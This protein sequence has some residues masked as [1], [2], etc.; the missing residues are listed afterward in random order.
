MRIRAVTR[1]ELPLLAELERAAGAPFAEIGMPE[2]AEDEPP[3]PGELAHY[4]ERG[5]ALVAEAP[6][7][8]IAGY[9]LAEPVDGALHVEQVSVHPDHARRGI[10]RAL[11]EHLAGTTDAPAL[12]LTTFA[13]V[14]WNAP[15]YERCGFRALAGDELTP[16]L[17]EIR[18]REAEHGLDRWPRLCM[19]RD[20]RP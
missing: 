11:I 9:L 20:L 10:G 19:R 1:D 4:L 15:Y 5:V 17:R 3:A 13:E 2:I 7:G 16:G 8:A 12:T 14:P 18:R 6:D